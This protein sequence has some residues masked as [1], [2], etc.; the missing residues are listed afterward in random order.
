MANVG[1]Q[2]SMEKLNGVK[3]MRGAEVEASQTVAAVGRMGI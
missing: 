3:K 1:R 2:P